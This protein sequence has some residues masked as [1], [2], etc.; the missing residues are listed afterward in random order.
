MSSNPEIR[1]DVPGSPHGGPIRSLPSVLFPA[2][3]PGRAAGTGP[4]RR[5]LD[6]GSPGAARRVAWAARRP[7]ALRQD[8]FPL[9]AIEID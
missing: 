4:G 7:A 6:D 9:E 3:A 1:R 5:G 2:R 8:P